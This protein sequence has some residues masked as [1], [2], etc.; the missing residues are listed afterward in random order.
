MAADKKEAKE[1]PLDK[2]T[3]KE[4]RDLAKEIT[5]LTGVHGMNKEELLSAIKKAKGIEEAPKKKGSVDTKVL[6]AAIKTVKA[7][8]KEAQAGDDN[9]KIDIFRRKLSRLKKKTRK[10]A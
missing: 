6:K 5:D 7:K 10:A 8:K 4:L 3:V 9:K 1:K 2:M